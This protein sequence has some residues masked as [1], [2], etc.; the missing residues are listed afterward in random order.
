MEAKIRTI[1]GKRLRKYREE[2]GM[3]RER[4]SEAVGIS[5]QFLA[6]VEN[7]KKGISVE[8]L[9]KICSYFDLS[10]DY[11]VLGRQDG[12]LNSPMKGL[13]Q[14]VPNEHLEEYINI[15]KSVNKLANAEKIEKREY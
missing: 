6:E 12:N 13:L 4:F 15:I 2:Q 14:E 11:L 5:P 7:G 10:A 9:Y 8:T 3:T 1:L